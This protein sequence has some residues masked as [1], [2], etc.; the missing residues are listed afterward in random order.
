MD[1]TS[2]FKLFFVFLVVSTCT[3]CGIDDSNKSDHQSPSTSEVTNAAEATPS[4][5]LEGY[6]SFKFGMTKPEVA[7]L[8]DCVKSFEAFRSMQHKGILS[9]IERID[10]HIREQKGNIS[11]LEGDIQNERIPERKQF[12]E[13]GIQESNQNIAKYQAEKDALHEN[14]KNISNGSPESL[15][16]AWLSERNN[17]CP[18]EVMGEIKKAFPV[19]DTGEKLA[20]IDIVIGEFNNDKFEALKAALTEKYQTSYEPTPEQ[21]ADFNNFTKQQLITTFSNGQVVL[22]VENI[23]EQ[24]FLVPLDF[25]S[26]YT[27]DK[28]VIVLSYVNAIIASQIAKKATSGQVNAADL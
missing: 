27:E 10:I 15:V 22:I 3:G 19:F 28:R 17:Y 24:K 26:A 13:N 11:R 5:S 14:A 8:P 16:D 7:T 9:D 21:V 20:A 12:Y 4:Q 25:G 2:V 23:K 1:R 6:K 18:I